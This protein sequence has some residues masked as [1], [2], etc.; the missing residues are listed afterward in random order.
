MNY[1]LTILS[2][3]I[4]DNEFIVGFNRFM[5]PIV[6]TD[7]RYVQYSN[8]L[9]LYHFD[10]K[11]DQLGVSDHIRELMDSFGVFVI[12]TEINS[13]TVFGIEGEHVDGLL[14]LGPDILIENFPY[15]IYPKDVAPDTDEE[16]DD[17]TDEVVQKLMQKFRVKEIEPTLDEVL[18]KIHAKGV[19][20]LSI[21]EQ[22]VLNQFN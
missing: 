5:S 11:L 9:L 10:T 20:S 19:S 22:A 16:E 21:Q 7:G 4:K 14:N 6:E 8:G 2:T 15:V 1:L 17:D 18:E 12:L 13:N 3:P